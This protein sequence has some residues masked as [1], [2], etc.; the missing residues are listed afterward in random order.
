MKRITVVT[1]ET[2]SIVIVC[3]PLVGKASLERRSGETH[4]LQKRYFLWVR[5]SRRW[6]AVQP[7]RFLSCADPEGDNFFPYIKSRQIRKMEDTVKRW[8]LFSLT[9]AL[10]LFA[11]GTTLLL[12]EPLWFGMWGKCANRLNIISQELHLRVGLESSKENTECYLLQPYFYDPLILSCILNS[13][14]CRK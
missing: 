2:R 1:K 14:I 3:S 13:S 12:Q 5:F 7:L 9:S 11:L 4:A 10:S 6:K 8:I